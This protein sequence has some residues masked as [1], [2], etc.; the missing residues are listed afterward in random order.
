MKS[1]IITVFFVILISHSETNACSV[2][3]YIDKI[4]GNIYVAN[5]EDYWYDTDAY[6]QIMPGSENEFA[7]LW[8]GWDDFAQGGINEHG[9]F[10]DGAVTP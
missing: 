9:L 3:Y 5:N 6:I 2:I 10:F 4:T 7:R 1:F 8:Y